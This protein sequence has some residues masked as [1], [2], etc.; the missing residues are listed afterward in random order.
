[1]TNL[2]IRK[3]MYIDWETGIIH[4]MDGLALDRFKLNWLGW[5]TK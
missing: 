5:K 4:I 1:M 3:N 2:S